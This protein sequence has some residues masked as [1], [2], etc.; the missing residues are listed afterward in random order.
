MR[1]FKVRVFQPVVGQ[2]LPRYY[3]W[4]IQGKKMKDRVSDME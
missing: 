1:G 2:Q 4:P 3:V